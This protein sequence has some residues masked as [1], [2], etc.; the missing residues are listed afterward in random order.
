[1][2][3]ANVTRP[4]HPVLAGRLR[5]RTGFLICAAGTPALTILFADDD[6][7]GCFRDRS[8]VGRP[9]AAL[10]HGGDVHRRLLRVQR[11]LLRGSAPSYDLD[12]VCRCRYRCRLTVRL[13][14]MRT[15]A[16]G[17]PRLLCS[18]EAAPPIGPAHRTALA[19][20]AAEFI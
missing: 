14:P 19:A 11:S 5:F 6:A 8:P 2:R 4:P 15:D 13:E 12:L 1:M 20:A 9:L 10:F 18:L 7:R 3:T 17:R 16:D